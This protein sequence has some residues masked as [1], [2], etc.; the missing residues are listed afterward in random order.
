[1][2]TQT[3]TAT[4]STYGSALVRGTHQLRIR[5]YG[6]RK[7]IKSRGF[8]AGGHLWAIS[9]VFDDDHKL[10]SVSLELLHTG[11]ARD[12]V[13]MATLRI[14]HPAG[15]DRRPSAERRSG[16][17]H[18]FP[19]WP[20]PSESTMATCRSWELSLPLPRHEYCYLDDD[21]ALN[22]N[23][24]QEDLV[25]EDG[26]FY[27]YCAV[28]VL[29]EDSDTPTDQISVVPPPKISED[30][31]RLLLLSHGEGEGQGELEMETELEL[32]RRRC[33]LP[34]V[35][36][37]VEEAEIQAH[38]L[39]LAMR[40]MLHFIYTDDLPPMKPC[41]MS[42]MA[43]DLLV[44]ADRYDIEGLRLACENIL[45]ENVT[46]GSI[47]PI[48]MAVHGR[49]SCQSLEDLCIQYM[50]SDPDVYAAVKG[51]EDY[52][53]LKETCCYFILD[54]T[55]KVAKTSMA[56]TPGP[57][58]PSSSNSRRQ[59][60][61]SASNS[62]EVVQGTHEFKIPHFIAVQ[63]KHGVGKEIS[64]STFQVG[65]Y[66]WRVKVY[67]S[68]SSEMAK[69]HVSVYIE[70]LTNP[71]PTGVKA[72]VRFMM[73]ARR[74]SGQI[75]WLEKTFT[76]KS[77]WGYAYFI[78][79]NSAKWGHVE[80][81]GSITIHCDVYV[82]KVCSTE[83]GTIATMSPSKNSS[84]L[85]QLLVCEQGSDIRFLVEDSE[86]RA[87]RLMIA[88]R[89]QTLYEA[90]EVVNKGD[91]HNILV[92]DTTVSVFKAMLHFIYTDELPAMVD[93]APGVDE[94]EVTVAQDLLVAACRFRLQRMKAMCE[95]LLA[96]LVSEENALSTL[97]LA[98]DLHCSNLENY[99]SEFIRL[100]KL[101][102]GGCV[103]Y[104]QLNK[105]STY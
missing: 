77:D 34:D 19:A 4:A 29:Q 62:S 52:K 18:V 51:T 71:G 23:S 53:E 84:H 15:C 13:A 97:E 35:T 78:T 21:W 93:L 44:A 79:T 81:D 8:E 28:D 14:E 46:P 102:Q 17:A 41:N 31:G 11:S 9:C 73:D 40:A 7:A 64:S 104:R 49:Q 82:A 3:K 75:K 72:T 100:A 83:D 38:K 1:M 66:E 70:L 95:N 27:V 33:M 61:M 24:Q 60:Q 20:T 10:S 63:R 59:Q 58:A 43:L 86:I 57:D 105:F 96:A 26:C 101:V 22:D 74:G 87:H 32:W 55:D 37:I 47:L 85:K 45:S 94:D 42:V 6:K 76:A 12:V 48:L 68:S 36:F 39:M 99:C 92:N 90:V 89:S 16:D 80:H 5:G 54:I 25:D 2:A 98:Q 103:D 91:D 30:L 69:G 56:N 67:P 65:G 88:A 50:A